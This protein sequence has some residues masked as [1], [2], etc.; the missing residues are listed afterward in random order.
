MN[1]KKK[2]FFSTKFFV[3]GFDAI[4]LVF[5]TYYKVTTIKA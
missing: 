4:L 2:I 3:F 5:Y 1:K